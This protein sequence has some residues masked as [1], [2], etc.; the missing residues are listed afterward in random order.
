MDSNDLLNL[1]ILRGSYSN[2]Q[3][4]HV[5]LPIVIVSPFFFGSFF[6]AK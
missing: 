5:K 3:Y 2:P 6:K 4:Q 1:A